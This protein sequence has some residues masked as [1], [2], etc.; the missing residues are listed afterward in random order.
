M[1]FFALVVLLWFA[2]ANRHSF[3]CTLTVS[4]CSG[5]PPAPGQIHYHLHS[6]VKENPFPTSSLKSFS[7][8]DLRARIQDPFWWSILELE[9]QAL[10]KPPSSF[11]QIS[12]KLDTIFI[13]RFWM[14]FPGKILG[15][16]NFLISWV[17]NQPTR[18]SQNGRAKQEE[19]Y[20]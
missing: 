10:Y 12:L 17:N 20:L 7:R 4:S 13:R 16:T 2:R 18:A 9:S 14:T 11:L 3:L 6:L 5:L 15:I 8:V 19:R 1:N